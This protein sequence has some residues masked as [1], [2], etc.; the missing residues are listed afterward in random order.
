MMVLGMKSELNVN[1]VIEGYVTK[2]ILSLVPF[3][4]LIANGKLP[5]RKEVVV[6]KR[7]KSM[8][9]DGMPEEVMLATNFILQELLEIFHNNEKTKDKLL[10]AD[11]NIGIK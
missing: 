2:G 10:V 3:E 9:M 1:R 7:R 5:N 6:T 4:R 11:P 8:K